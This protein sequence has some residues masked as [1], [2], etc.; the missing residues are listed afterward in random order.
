[1]TVMRR[2]DWSGSEISWVLSAFFIGYAIFQV[3]LCLTYEALQYMVATALK[4][5]QRP[6]QNIFTPKNQAI[7][8][9]SVIPFQ[10]C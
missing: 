5:V 4:K 6:S 2:L 1:M 7:Q 8:I 10:W 9:V 3:K